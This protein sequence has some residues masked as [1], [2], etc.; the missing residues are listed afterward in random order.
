M[1][2]VAA[3]V[4]LAMFAPAPGLWAQSSVGSAQE[5][6][7]RVSVSAFAGEPSQWPAPPPDLIRRAAALGNPAAWLNEADAPIA[8]W[9]KTALTTS[10]TLLLDVSAEGR[11]T[12]CTSNLRNAAQSPAWSAELCPLLRERARLV[13]ALRSDGTRMAD[14]FVFQANFQYSTYRTAEGGPLIQSYGLSPA[15]P[16]SSDFNPQLESW[17]P[18]SGWLRHVTTSP[19]LKLKA[20]TPGEAVLT[21]P[22]IGLIVADPKSGDPACRVVLSSSDAKLD[23]QACDHVRK[24]L[25]PQWDAGVRFPVRR[26]PL[27]LSPVGKGFRVIQPD[28]DAARRAGVDSP[29]LARLS[30]LWRPHAVGAQRVGLYG[31]LGPDLRP[32]GC[33]IYDSS[34]SDPA[35]TAACRLFMTEAKFS[36][37]RDVFGQV[38]QG[39]SWTSLDLWPQ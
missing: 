39:A 25:K 13:P 2:I 27:L 4:M 3:G 22:A 10:V 34:G 6:Y 8:A 37:A 11:V 12:G 28:G 29:E 24:K 26:W 35:D 23:Q 14:Q 21:G 32:E 7:R 17:P 19:A 9:R 5:P 30:A 1:R 16:P 15:P 36:A 20:E 18:P 38:I 33:R 31:K